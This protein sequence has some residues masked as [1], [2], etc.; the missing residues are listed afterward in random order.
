M[1]L[2]ARLTR[3][4]G[5]EIRNPLNN[6]TLAMDAL[7][8]EVSSTEPVKAYIDIIKRN[9]D[10]ISNLIR[11]LLE[12]S[13][14]AAVDLQ[15]V[16][17]SHIT[18]TVRVNTLDR[19]RLR[20]VSLE[21]AG[22]DH[23]IQA[24]PVQFAT[25]LTNIVINALEAIRTENGKVQLIVDTSEGG[26]RFQI[27]DNG[28]GMTEEEQELLFD[29]FYTNK[30]GGIGLGLTLALNI[31]EAHKGSIEVRSSKGKGSVFEILIPLGSV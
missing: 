18:N 14:P 26:I 27:I 30:K 25:A 29:P 13:R 15:L 12:S 17:T 16:S 28:I 7:E 31:I 9:V 8:H 11:E 5:H 10:R 2:T 24:D 6:I 3:S 22:R 4:I 1:A 23:Q 19:F 21:I 20:E